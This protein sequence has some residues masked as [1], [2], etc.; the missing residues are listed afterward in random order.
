MK[1][2][3]R[4]YVAGRSDRKS[5]SRSAKRGAAAAG[6]GAGQLFY[7][8]PHAK[9]GMGLRL[10]NSIGLQIAVGSPIQRI[11]VYLHVVISYIY[12]YI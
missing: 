12:I 2:R 8:L 10:T 3:G 9:V 6:R 11:L 7:R 1:E 5:A 4:W